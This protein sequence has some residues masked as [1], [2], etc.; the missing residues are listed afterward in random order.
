SFSRKRCDCDRLH[1]RSE[2]IVSKTHL[3]NQ[4]TE[5]SFSG[6][7][8]R[9]GKDFLSG[10]SSVQKVATVAGGDIYERG[11]SLR[12]TV[13]PSGNVSLLNTFHN[14]RTRHVVPRNRSTR[15]AN[16]D[17]AARRKW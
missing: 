4:I 9:L 17:L 1:Q 6:Q 5:N 16:Y 14:R 15:A 13:L 10:H 2:A 12:R 7:F 11:I 3:E 8:L